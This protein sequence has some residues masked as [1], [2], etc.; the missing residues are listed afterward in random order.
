MKAERNKKKKDERKSG[1]LFKEKSRKTGQPYC[2]NG[3]KKLGKERTFSQE[4]F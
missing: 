1:K 3:N 2:Q 4:K